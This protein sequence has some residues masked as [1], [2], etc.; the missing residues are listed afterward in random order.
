M[1]ATAWIVAPSPSA[2]SSLRA[3]SRNTARR[4][5]CGTSKRRYATSATA[6][7]TLSTARSFT[8]GKTASAK[9]TATVTSSVGSSPSP[10]G[11]GGAA[12]ES[13]RPCIR[14]RGLHR[15]RPGRAA[16]APSTPVTTRSEN[17]APTGSPASSTAWARGEPSVKCSVSGPKVSP[18]SAQSMRTDS[19]PS[20]SSR[21]TPPPHSTRIR[22][23]EPFQSRSPPKGSSKNEPQPQSPYPGA[24]DG[25]RPHMSFC[26]PRRSGS[27][28]P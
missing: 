17:T 5:G 12:S 21:V 16:S 15:A 8:S 1:S 24:P 27:G 2:A 22:E 3:V 18:L 23:G 26:A 4:T 13:G 19:A 20:R 6:P 25:H 11:G 7:S 28:W 14:V 10:T 9:A